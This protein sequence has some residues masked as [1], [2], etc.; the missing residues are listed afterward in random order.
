MFC[1][2]M[3]TIGKIIIMQN[4]IIVVLHH[5]RRYDLRF[6]FTKYHPECVDRRKNNEGFGHVHNKVSDNIITNLFIPK[7]IHKIKIQH[8]LLGFIQ[9]NIHNSLSDLALIPIVG[10]KLM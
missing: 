3:L 9:M 7:H 1:I 8:K 2:I 10:K 6:K 5:F 4:N